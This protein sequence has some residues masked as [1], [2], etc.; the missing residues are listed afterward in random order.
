MRKRIAEIQTRIAQSCAR[1]GRNPADVRLVAVSK[2][3]SEEA[4]REA[5]ACGLR[6]FG[7]NY[8]QELS[9][10]AS[11]LADLQDIRWHFIGPLQRNKAGLVVPHLRVIHS[12]HAAKLLKRIDHV[13]TARTDVL[14]QINISEEATKSGA[15]EEELQELLELAEQTTKV[16]CIGLMT[17]PPAAGGP[18]SSRS[19]FRKLRILRDL[20]AAKYGTLEHLSMGMTGDLEVAIEEGATMVR[21]GTAIFGPR[22]T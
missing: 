3:H 4:I 1:V 13:A 8:A 18:E 15:K 20:H 16:R 22:P 14:I 5:Y 7:E 19:V 17:I 11:A 2:R 6:D 12:V 10:K 21:I 9:A